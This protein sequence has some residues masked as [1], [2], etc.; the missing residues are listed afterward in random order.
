MRC[1]PTLALAA[2]MML[3]APADAQELTEAQYQEAHCIVLYVPEGDVTEDVVQG[4]VGANLSA[5]AS[6]V[7]KQ[8][9]DACVAKYGWDANALNLATTI[10]FAFL[11]IEWHEAM[12]EQMEISASLTRNLQPV[13]DGLSSEEQTALFL[14]QEGPELEAK[15]RRLFVAQGAPGSDGAFMVLL[16]L[17]RDSLIHPTQLERFADARF[18]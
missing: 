3:A 10:A 11:S 2:S 6:A 16:Q 15:V 1:F 9:Q 18:P 14:S 5:D 4:Y 12:A 17:F 8:A 7:V 13:A